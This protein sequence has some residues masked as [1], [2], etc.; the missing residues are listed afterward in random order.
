[1]N[2]TGKC[3]NSECN[4]S[5]TQKCH[6]GNDSPDSCLHWEGAAKSEKPLKDKIT[7]KKLDVPWTGDDFKIND[8]EKVSRRSTPF[9]IGLIGHAGSAKT[10]FLGALYTLLA[11][12]HN[13][14]DY[15]FSGSETLLRWE[16]LMRKL[17]F[18]KGKVVFPPPTPSGGDYYS[19]LHLMLRTQNALLKDILFT[20][21]SGE[22]F[23]QWATDKNDTE[24]EN[25]R[26]LSQHANGFIF[27]INAK[28]I[29]DK[30]MAGVNDILDMAERLKQD[31]NGRPVIGV[32][33][34]ADEIESVNPIHV[35]KVEHE[36][37]NL[38]EQIEIFQISNYLDI[39]L[40]PDPKSSNNLILLNV[41][42]NKLSAVKLSQTFV[43]KVPSNSDLFLTYRG[44]GKQQ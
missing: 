25:V 41:L 26:W 19:F 21:L 18:E 22:V 16:F 33:S 6:I 5:I 30:R 14:K 37:R 20:D 43:T 32:W 15:K 39:N 8:I 44:H 31:L 11:N 2:N 9:I 28:T 13:L 10:S 40:N 23:T 7:E 35:L 1:M 42:L 36:L 17:R 38:F 29:A 3:E 27:F 34:K 12:G 24:A 4:A